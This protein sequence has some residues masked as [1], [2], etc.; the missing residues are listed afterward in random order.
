MLPPRQYVT[1][2]RV[3]TEKQGR[4]GLGLDAQVISAEQL[5][6]HNNGEI[7]A[8]FQE[9]ETGTNSDRPEL[10]KALRFCRQK[11]AILLIA[12]ID[13]LA[14]NVAFVANLIESKVEFISC[15]NPHANKTM[16]QMMAVWAEHESDEISKRTIAALAVA[17]ARGVKLGNP[18]P[19]LEKMHV[20]RVQRARQFRENVYPL[21]KQLR[22]RG[23]TLKAIADHLNDQ[24]I[25]SQNKRLWHPEAV[26][27]VL[28]RH[29]ELAYSL[30]NIT[31]E[32]A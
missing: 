13:R 22:D 26:R 17:K 23:M 1:Y 30:Q 21:I 3:S 6:R 9:V 32:A 19:P 27:L 24:G 4:S 31:E 29:D 10:Q 8:S 11:K 16:S 28:L 5:V 14:R 2:Y 12:K 7:I 20:R 25:R 18:C 15:D